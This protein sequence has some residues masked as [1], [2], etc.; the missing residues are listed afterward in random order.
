M[1]GADRRHLDGI[2]N[3][4]RSY[5]PAVTTEL[6]THCSGPENAPAILLV[7]GLGGSARA[8]DRVVPLLEDR[9]RVV[10]VDLPGAGASPPLTGT[11][12]IEA[13]ADLLPAALDAVGASRAI[14]VGHSMG[15]VIATAL[16]ERHAARIGSLVLVN[17]PPSR[18]SRLAAG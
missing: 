6:P 8:W 9:F 16:A 12:T 4:A 2:A 7:H 14:V 15:G 1:H 3:S 17:A 13:M 10:A 5:V 18:E 11:V